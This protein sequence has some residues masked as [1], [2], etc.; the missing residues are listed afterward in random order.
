MKHLITELFFYIL[1]Y[2]FNENNDKRQIEIRL[3]SN[4]ITLLYPEFYIARSL[5]NKA[6]QNKIY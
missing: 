3:K 1:Y 5:R 4:N 2:A 6:K